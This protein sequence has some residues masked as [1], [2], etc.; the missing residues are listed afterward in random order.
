MLTVRK[1]TQ[2][3]QKQYTMMISAL[4]LTLKQ[5]SFSEIIF[6]SVYVTFQNNNSPLPTY[7][8]EINFSLDTN[9]GPGLDNIPKIFI[10]NAVSSLVRPSCGYHIMALYRRGTF[11]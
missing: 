8:D 10:K 11:S 3:S 7:T 9:K 5:W 4:L 2:E 1:T 6:Q